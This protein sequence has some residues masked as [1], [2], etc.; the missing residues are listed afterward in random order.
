MECTHFI[1]W[2]VTHAIP[3]RPREA[4][5]RVHPSGAIVD[6][7]NV[8][9]LALPPPSVLALVLLKTH[10]GAAAH[11]SP[12]FLEHERDVVLVVCHEGVVV[13]DRARVL[14]A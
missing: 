5:A 2:K 7:E 9:V 13:V 8:R 1:I 14:A 6:L 11:P 12:E 10:Q 4:E 3:N